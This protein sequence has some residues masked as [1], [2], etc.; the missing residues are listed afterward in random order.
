MPTLHAL[1]VKRDFSDRVLEVV[2]A[3]LQAEFSKVDEESEVVLLDH[4]DG[5][6]L[7]W[8]PAPAGGWWGETPGPFNDGP[9]RHRRRQHHTRMSS[10]HGL[11]GQLGRGNK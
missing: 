6:W 1:P 11:G 5:P 8:A 2:V 9:T 10:R 7:K 4:P 3:N